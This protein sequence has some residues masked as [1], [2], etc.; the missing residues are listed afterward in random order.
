MSGEKKRRWWPLGRDPAGRHRALDDSKDIAPSVMFDR[1]PGETPTIEPADSPQAGGT[2]NQNVE[3]QD[4]APAVEALTANALGVDVPDAD[5]PVADPPTSGPAIRENP[6]EPVVGIIEMPTA[7]PT[8]GN[9]R[10][11]PTPCLS[12]GARYRA[13]MIVLDG[14]AIGSYYIAGVSQCGTSHLINGSSRQDAYDF[15]LRARI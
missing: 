11:L 1:E 7:A 15:V 12:S 10:K 14:L 4:S 2:E 5:I 9:V 13:P 8:I 6:T 3:G